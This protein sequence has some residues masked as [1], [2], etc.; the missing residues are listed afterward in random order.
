MIIKVFSTSV[1]PKCR[2]LK[3]FLESKGIDFE[4][5]NMDTAEGMTELFMLGIVA[6]EAPVLV[7][8]NNALYSSDLFKGTEIQ[9][10]KI[11]SFIA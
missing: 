6:F 4:S 2:R 5:M 11:L 9:E 3:A 10:E 8:G 7:C 1:C